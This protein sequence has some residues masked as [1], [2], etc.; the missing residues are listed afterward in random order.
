MK[1]VVTAYRM[2]MPVLALVAVGCVFAVATA[3]DTEYLETRTIGLLV[4][5]TGN[6]PDTVSGQVNGAVD[7][8]LDQFNRH[9]YLSGADWRLEVVKS[10]T[11]SDPAKT[12]ALVE[13]LNNLGIKA[14]IGPATSSNLDNIQ[15]YVAANGMVVISYASAASNLSIPGDRIFRT[16]PDTVTYANAKYELLLH[17][18]IRE[19]VIVFS[20]D[21]IGRSVNHT[22]YEVVGSDA[23]GDIRIRDTIMF[24]PD[25]GDAY[26][27]AAQ[28]GAALAGY[29]H[30]HIGVVV[31]DYTG[32]I[33]DIIRHVSGAS[34]PGMN[35][36][37]WYGPEHLMDD[38]S[39]DDAVRQFLIE[40]EY[41]TLSL[42][43]AENDLNIRI[44]S[45]LKDTGTYAYAAYDALFILGNAI[46]VAGNATDA[47]AIA[48]AIPAVARLGHGIEIH[49]H[50]QD[51]LIRGSGSL[52]E[53]AG[54]LG[55]SIML[56][57]AG[58]LAMSDYTVSSISDDGFRITH[59]YDSA[60]NDIL[61]FASPDKMRIGALVSET[62][63]L[64][65]GIGIAVSD[66]IS[67]AVY[68]Y[69][70]DLAREG[71]DWRID[72][73]KRDDR[74]SPPDTLKNV[75]AFYSDGI[76]SMIGPL[77]S[78]STAS[79]M[80]F[81]N[82]NGMVAIGYASSS[83][84]LALDDNIF[85]MRASDE[86]TADVYAKLL[87][88]DDIVDVVIVYRDDP[89]GRSLNEHITE[90]ASHIDAVTVHPSISYAPADSATDYRIV[91]DTLKSRLAGLDMSGVAVML[92]GFSESWDILDIARIDPAL[93]EG[94]WYAFLTS[95]DV[96][97]SDEQ[98]SWMEKVGYSS[99]ITRP[100][101]NTLS[102]HIDANVAGANFYTYHAYDALY[103]LADAIKR[104]GT[105]QDAEA[106]AA[107]I[108]KE[109][110]HL[111]AA[112]GF[113]TTLNEFGDLVGSDYN[114]YEMRDGAFQVKAL[115]DHATDSLY[116]LVFD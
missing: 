30:A 3:T 77:T 68:N 57:E 59:K 7:L 36:T 76:R 27:V 39:A 74:T 110:E 1:D 13:E 79:I 84:A 94:R 26:E 60:T 37:R 22:I 44:D 61:E 4:P 86:Q 28:L 95:P 54:A 24:Q 35:D 105:T 92:F 62:G 48:A 97:P 91:I 78:G 50:V 53:Y 83:P 82:D 106:L 63:S 69:N 2:C 25:T 103:T 49:Q 58:D 42:A 19:V 23:T 51:P 111:R 89:W 96:R 15:D 12:L 14:I 102:R 56:N 93:Q 85:R 107:A 34:I 114:V 11:G 109:A 100:I 108:P 113:Q 80:D 32:M 116:V 70:L 73:L 45:I 6:V 72:I 87:D 98:I 40:T 88:H 5:D 21:A 20:D 16:V 112:I 18:D 104:V 99:V 31:Y 71:A 46:G 101:S 55:P 43:H 52:F 17:D 29:D 8:A 115:Y 75:E 33:V 47:D 64:A 90:R 81:V 66:A 41:R 10:D 67:L 38:I 65:A 9:L